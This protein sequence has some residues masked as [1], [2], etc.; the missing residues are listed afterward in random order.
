M[1]RI[2]AVHGRACGPTGRGAWNTICGTDGTTG[3]ED[4][5]T[6][7][8]CLWYMGLYVPLTKLAEHQAY[9]RMV[10]GRRIVETVTRI[11]T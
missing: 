4:K 10:E 7:R 11:T 2:F 6:C 9:R 3:D 8:R 1:A 5:V